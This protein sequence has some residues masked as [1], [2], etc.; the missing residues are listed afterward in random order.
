MKTVKV[1]SII[2]IDPGAS[3]GIAMWH[4]GRAEAFK[5]PSDGQSLA[6]IIDQYSGGRTL[7]FLEK[8]CLFRSD[9]AVIDGRAHMGKLYRVQK[10]L[11]NYEGIKATLD[12]L[13]IP[14]VLVPPRTWQAR[15]LLTSSR[16][17]DKASRK[18]IYKER[19][20]KLYPNMPVTLWNADALLLMHFGR[21]VLKS[22]PFWLFQNMDEKQRRILF[23]FL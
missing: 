20:K 6:R 15:L 7:V 8:L 5:M 10:L 22:Q 1:D 16:C 18:H 17:R 9:I 23:K 21:Y 11:A 19:A 3:G 14:F 4:D 13:G 12:V 2:G